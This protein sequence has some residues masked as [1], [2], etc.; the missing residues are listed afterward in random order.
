MIESKVMEAIL[1]QAGQIMLSAKDIEKAVEEKEGTANFVTKYDVMVQKLLKEKLLGCCPDAVF[2]G[3]EED[4]QG[5][6]LHG[7]AFIVD[8]IDGTT[9]FIKHYDASAVSVAMLWDG[10]VVMGATFNPY[11]DEFFYGQK[12]KGAFCNGVPIHVAEKGLADNLICFGTSP[13]YPELIT[14][15]FRIAEALLRNGMDLRRSGSA[16]IDLCDVARGRTGLLFEMKLSPWDYA[17]SS[18]ILTEAGGCISQMDGSPIIFDGPCS[19]VAGTPDAW[20]EF[21]SVKNSLQAI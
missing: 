7:A 20:K 18:L 21:F 8:P 6:F 15:T 10:E 1:R 12:G 4:V 19:V 2:V 16:V 13:Y 17:A 14:D 11:R 5:D 3:E 9:N